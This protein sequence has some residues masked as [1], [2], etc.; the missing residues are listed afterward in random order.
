MAKKTLSIKQVAY[1]AMEIYRLA[2]EA[3][4]FDYGYDY[5]EFSGHYHM[6]KA[7]VKVANLAEK[8]GYSPD[9]VLD[10]INRMCDKFW[11]P[12]MPS[13]N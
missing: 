9:E 4:A 5:G 1:M 3:A 6:N 7:D 11:S 13:Q 8:Y 10:E 12:V 2:D